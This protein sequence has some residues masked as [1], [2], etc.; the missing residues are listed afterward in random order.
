MSDDWELR[1]ERFWSS[2]SDD[3]HEAE[4]T[5]RAMKSL[6]A[7]RPADDAA[8]V[9]EWASVHDYLGR[10]AQ[11][12]PLY[13]RALLLGLDEGRL[14]R[15]QIQL[16]SSLRNLGE[17][18][19]AIAVLERMEGSDAVGEARQAF[20]ALALFDAGR[21]RDALRVALLALGRTLPAYGGAVS[22]Y[23]EELSSGG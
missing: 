18:G 19:E 11:A 1:V 15:A 22:R 4:A 23:A 6:V 3:E 21:S 14:P 12:V 17:A 16:A 2:A 7:E 13:R 5:L 9:Y 10:E 20:L 8:A